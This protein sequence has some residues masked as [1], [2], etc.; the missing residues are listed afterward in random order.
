MSRKYILAGGGTS[1]H[2][3]P[4]L[5]I[6]DEIVRRE[7]DAQILF[8]GTA[9]GLESE[10]VPRA[11]YAFQ[12]IRARGLPNRPGKE[13]VKA[14]REILAGRKQCMKLIRDFKPDAV[15]GTGGYVCSPLISA[16]AR[17]KVP[18][19]LHE[20]N[21]Y[22][23]RSNRMLAGR[24]QSVCIS[25]PGTEKYFRTSAPI[26]LT[27]NPVREIFFE[28]DRD[29]ARQKLGI[30]EQ[31]KLVLIMGGSLGAA[32]L[33]NAVLGLAE[34]DKWQ[35]FA[36]ARGKIKLLLAAGK[37]HYEVV[38]QMA[39][40]KKLDCDVREYL[41]DAHLWMAAADLVVARAG[42]MTCAE[43][44]ALGRAS[45]LIPYPYAAGDHQTFNAGALVN[46]GAAIMQ[47]DE[48][49]NSSWLSDTL[50]DMLSDSEKLSSMGKSAK[51]LAKP[52]ASG[53]IYKCL[54][55]IIK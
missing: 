41:F 52:Q 25:F 26:V 10:M 48:L 6:A 20:Q 8:C 45:V 51:L 54:A 2:I 16:A 34:D 11:G 24:C 19:L 1:G 31:E 27:G 28:L 4:A 17:L 53:D 36:N 13:A 43:L 14:L 21:A 49:C 35:A 40:A 3:N 5:A 29:Q 55:G 12:E 7:P 42:A 33:N 39:E 15:I 47:S 32:K 38:S 37:Q 23:G 44:A 9:R 50:I 30:D 18:A 46:A 22:P